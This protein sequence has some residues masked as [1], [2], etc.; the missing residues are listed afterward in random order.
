MP[1][2][3][4]PTVDLTPSSSRVEPN[5]PSTS[6]KQQAAKDV[7]LG[8]EDSSK[9]R[10]VP[11]PSRPIEVVEVTSYAQLPIILKKL[12]NSPDTVRLVFPSVPPT[13]DLGKDNKIRAEQQAIHTLIDNLHG[14]ALADLT[15]Q[16]IVLVEQSHIFDDLRDKDGDL[17]VILDWWLHPEGP[18]SFNQNSQTKLQVA[19]VVDLTAATTD[20]E[21]AALCDMFVKGVSNAGTV[22]RLVC[23]LPAVEKQAKVLGASALEALSSAS[24]TPSVNWSAV[25]VWI[26]PKDTWQQPS[27][28]ENARC[29]SQMSLEELE[30]RIKTNQRIV[31][32]S[33]PPRGSNG[34]KG[35]FRRFLDFALQ[36]D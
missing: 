4:A 5:F 11:G 32:Q 8:F 15:A 29:V 35:V 25:K 24:L 30:E 20:K 22:A 9:N 21:R 13:G 3:V 16:T 10:W 36:D 12:N 2:V 19:H 26:T 6:Q 7:L 14:N 34:R 31:I 1:G 18:L 27:A 33:R 28:P 17:K 23:I